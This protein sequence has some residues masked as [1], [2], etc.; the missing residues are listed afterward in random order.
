[1]VWYI[2]K[3]VFFHTEFL[4]PFDT[5]KQAEQNCPRNLTTGR[6]ESHETYTVFE[7]QELL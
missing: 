5:R 3:E 6:P 7:S 4:G 2:K 1:M